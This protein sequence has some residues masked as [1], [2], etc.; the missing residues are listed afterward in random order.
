M[1][2]RFPT[3]HSQSACPPPAS[4]RNAPALSPL[5]IPRPP[6][7]PSASIPPPPV[8]SHPTRYPRPWPTSPRHSH[9]WNAATWSSARTSTPSTS[10]SAAWSPSSRPPR[11]PPAEAEPEPYAHE[12]PSPATPVL[13]HRN[14]P[15]GRS[16]RIIPQHEEPVVIDPVDGEPSRAEL[17]WPEPPSHPVPNGHPVPS[18][19]H[20]PEPSYA[21]VGEKENL[22]PATQESA[23]ASSSRLVL[24]SSDPAENHHQTPDSDPD[25]FSPSDQNRYSEETHA[26][27]H[28]DADS[29]FSTTAAPENSITAS[30]R[31]AAPTPFAPRFSRFTPPPAPEL[32]EAPIPQST[33]PAAP[34]APAASAPSSSSSVLRPLPLP[35]GFFGTAPVAE[36]TSEDSE[37]T[38]TLP[39]RRRRRNFNIIATVLIVLA[40][41]GAAYFLYTRSL[42]AG[43]DSSGI[44]PNP[45][46][47]AATSGPLTDQPTNS[48]AAAPDPGAKSGRVLDSRSAFQPRQNAETPSSGGSFRPAGTF[49]PSSVMDGRLLSAPQPDTSHVPASARG[50]VVMEANISPAGQVEDV[51]ILGGS[52]PLRS[53]AIDAVRNWQYKPYLV[54]GSPAEVRTIIR[55]DFTPHHSQPAERG[56]P[57]PP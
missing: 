11:P 18:E 52:A 32:V 14:P 56:A 2:A 57:S 55:V 5:P 41:L 50:V 54:N 40:L 6:A 33:S 27:P 7:S 24:T 53:P 38:T 8:P 30:R 28:T 34:A 48:S 44:S 15:S 4:S 46:P 29:A 12:E 37:P 36:E 49:V 45:A 1:N 9:A 26:V 39:A 31:S 42:S 43:N 3:V 51:H 13:V 25:A 20:E 47:R 19:T 10:A 23:H 16:F 17:S 21:R 22:G 35:R